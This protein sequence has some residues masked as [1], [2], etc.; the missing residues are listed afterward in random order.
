MSIDQEKRRITLETLREYLDEL[1]S[2]KERIDKEI[3]SI[4]STLKSLEGE[5]PAQESL[6]LSP[7]PKY[8]SLKGN[9]KAVETF[10]KDNPGRSFSATEIANKLKE[11][12]YQTE[13]Q[14]FSSTVHNVAN[15]LV[16]RG[17]AE[18][19]NKSFFG[20][21]TGKRRVVTVFRFKEETPEQKVEEV[22]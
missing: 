21:K 19:K 18:K 20:K 9:T 16:D 5:Y 1:M 17:I 12:G 10:L 6:V 4:E 13:I 7:T 2:E 8:S 15:R 11:L 22:A 14:Q 3:R